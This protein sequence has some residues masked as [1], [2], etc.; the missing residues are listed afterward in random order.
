MDIDKY[1]ADRVE[2]RER[3]Y[4]GSEQAVQNAEKDAAQKQFEKQHADAKLRRAL[5]ERDRALCDLNADK[6]AQQAVKAAREALAQ[7]ALEEKA[8]QKALEEKAAKEAME[9]PDY[10]KDYDLSDPVHQVGFG[11][12]TFPFSLCLH[13]LA[14]LSGSQQ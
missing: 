2:Q 4:R 8:A 12:F 5:L 9:D 7:K 10:Y 14:V 13:A 11:G 1:W 3:A 6:E